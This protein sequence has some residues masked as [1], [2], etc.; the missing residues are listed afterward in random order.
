M[1]LLLFFNLIIFIKLFSFELCYFFTFPFVLLFREQDGQANPSQLAF[2]FTMFFFYLTWVFFVWPCFWRSIFF[3]PI[4]CHVWEV[5]WLNLGWLDFSSFLFGP[6][7]EGLF[8]LS[9]FHATFV[10]FLISSFCIKLFAFELC[11]FFIFL[12]VWLFR[13]RVEKVNPGCL[14]GFFMFF[15]WT[16]VFSTRSSFW[17]FY[18]DLTLLV[19]GSSSYPELTRGFFFGI[20]FSKVFFFVLIFDIKLSGLNFRIFFCFFYSLTVTF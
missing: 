18:H 8:F 4:S 7:F 16:L 12:I 17:I 5:S 14:K 10:I 9:R 6:V 15:Y 13:E 2:S 20:V 19:V 3:I 11:Y 1:T